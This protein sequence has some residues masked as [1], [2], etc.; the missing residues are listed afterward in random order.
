MRK[1]CAKVPSSLEAE[2]LGRLRSWPSTYRRV[3]YKRK[4]GL[5]KNFIDSSVI[6]L[7]C[8][9]FKCERVL[10]FGM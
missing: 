9:G 3:F 8:E 10:R 4:M 2:I 1:P 6:G 7:K 5:V